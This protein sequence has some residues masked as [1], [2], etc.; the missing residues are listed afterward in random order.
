MP[1]KAASKQQ[2]QQQQQQQQQQKK[3]QEPGVRRAGDGQAASATSSAAS[4]KS[5]ASSVVDLNDVA[6]R[7]EEPEMTHS[8]LIRLEA[9]QVAA[10][11]DNLNGDPYS[12]LLSPSF[13]DIAT[14]SWPT[15]SP[16]PSRKSSQ[17]QQQQP[18]SPLLKRALSS[19]LAAQS[20]SESSSMMLTCS[21]LDPDYFDDEQRRQALLGQLAAMERL[22]IDENANNSPP[23]VATADNSTNSSPVADRKKLTPRDRRQADKERYQTYTLNANPS[24]EDEGTSKQRNRRSDEPERFKTQTISK[25]EEMTLEADAKAVINTMKQEQLSRKN[26]NSSELLDCE[27][28]SLVSNE[29]EPS[30]RSLSSRKA[31]TNAVVRIIRPEDKNPPEDAVKGIRGRRR[32]LYP[33]KVAPVNNHRPI[34]SRSASP[35][36]PSPVRPNRTSALR[37]NNS[38]NQQQ[39]IKCP[40]APALE[41][42]SRLRGSSV[43][44]PRVSSAPCSPRQPPQPQQLNRRSLEVAANNKSITDP[45]HPPPLAALGKQGT[46]TKETSSADEQVNNYNFLL[47]HFI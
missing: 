23:K 28:L 25:A 47:N 9:N 27:T 46:F 20:G 36:S 24:K 1:P 6:V 33:V 40:S 17:H 5:T 21:V 11:I 7:M 43:K 4:T 19:S 22:A 29:S 15:G 8:S 45:V 16:T 37:Q 31:A 44:S 2:P 42:Q 18:V 35:A 34:N 12:S 41:S 10:Q 3:Q 13:I 26:S 14:S 39:R 32:V 38:T 30:D